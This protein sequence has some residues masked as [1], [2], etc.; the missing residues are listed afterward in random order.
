[1]FEDGCKQVLILF[2]AFDINVCGQDNKNFR[3]FT[4]KI[5]YNYLRSNKLSQD[6]LSELSI[7]S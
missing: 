6:R 1:M 7:G 4:L 5:I 2:A 3:K